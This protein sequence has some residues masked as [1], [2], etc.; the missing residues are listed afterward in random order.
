[1]LLSWFPG[2]RATLNGR[3]IVLRPDTLTGLV[4][5][6]IPQTSAWSELVIYFGA[7]TTRQAGWWMMGSALVGTLWLIRVRGLRRHQEQDTFFD[8]LALLSLVDARLMVVVMLSFL[9]VLG[10]TTLPN[11]PVALSRAPFYGLEGAADLRTQ[12]ETGLEVMAYRVEDA[13]VPREGTLK[14]TV[15]WRAPRTLSANTRVRAYLYN[16]NRQLRA[17]ETPLRHPGDYPTRLWR[18]GGYVADSYI[19]E[20][21][22]TLFPGSYQIFIEA[23]TCA[24]DASPDCE[25]RVVQRF[26]DFSDVSRPS[27]S[28]MLPNII[29]ILD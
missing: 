11:A 20:L 28:M 24:D 1:M 19:I 26:L 14:F 8:D 9:G 10:L 21:P 18:P 29:T 16:V 3:P 12:T 4:Q 7:T 6:T 22:P 2:W 27:A 25:R 17:L 13:L 23:F 15:Y 5:M